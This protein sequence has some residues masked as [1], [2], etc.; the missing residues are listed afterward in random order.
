MLVFT[1][2]K[3]LFYILI[4]LSKYS[5]GQSSTDIELHNRYWTY[6]EN[7]RKYFI[8]IGKENEQYIAFVE[9]CRSISAD[10]IN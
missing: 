1:K 6:R 7:F 4:L 2:K 10:N 8:S 5:I 3:L 9:I